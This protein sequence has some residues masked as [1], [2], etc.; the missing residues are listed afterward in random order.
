MIPLIGKVEERHIKEGVRY[1][2]S[3]CMLANSLADMFVMIK[4]CVRDGK[5]S[6]SS[7]DHVFIWDCY[8]TNR[9]IVL[10]IDYDQGCPIEPFEFVIYFSVLTDRYEIDIKS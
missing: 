3:L 2:A 10:L 9:L 6:F 1:H 7:L 5:V 4:P 8:I